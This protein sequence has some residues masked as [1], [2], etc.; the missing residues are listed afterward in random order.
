MIKKSKSKLWALNNGIEP[1][2]N[3][4]IAFP[5]TTTETKISEKKD[6]K[7]KKEKK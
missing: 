7:E 6:K 4:I 3:T 1:E 2:T 5:R